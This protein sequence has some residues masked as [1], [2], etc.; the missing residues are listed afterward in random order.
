VSERIDRVDW[1]FPQEERNRLEALVSTAIRDI[2]H[3]GLDEKSVEPTPYF[4]LQRITESG[5][6]LSDKERDYIRAYMEA[7]YGIK[8][9]TR[10]SQWS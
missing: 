7:S 3:P 2:N 1:E 8:P 5:Q 10:S 4:V 6:E 9:D